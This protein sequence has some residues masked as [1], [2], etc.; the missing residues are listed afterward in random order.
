VYH[1]GDLTNLFWPQRV[2]VARSFA[3]GR[4]P[5]WN[6]YAWGGSPFLAS[7]QPGVFDPTTWLSLWPSADAADLLDGFD[8]QRLIIFLILAINTFA[9]ARAGL[10]LDRG[11][12][13]FGALITACCGFLWW[14]HFDHVNQLSTMAWYPL[15]LLGSLL[16]FRGE[17]RRP[18][19]IISSA[20]GLQVLAGHPQ[21]VAFGCLATAVVVLCLLIF[22]RSPLPAWIRT[23]LV[24]GT[25]Y[26]LGNLIGAVQ[27]LP[28]VELSGLS[29]RI[30]APPD[31]ASTF[32]MQWRH[33]LR[34]IWPH[35]FGVFPNFWPPD[36]AYAEVSL[37]VGRIPLALALL[38]VGA[39]M[40]RTFSGRPDPA[41]REWRFAVW[42]L[43][44]LAAFSI[45]YAAGPNGP[46]FEPLTL[47]APPLDSFRV[48]AR[49]LF[50]LDLSLAL[51]AAAGLQRLLGP[52]K[53]GH[54]GA[55]LTG[56][57]VGLIAL[58]ALADLWAVSRTDYIRSPTP[59][60][61]AEAVSPAVVVMTSQDE[62]P[63]LYR[64]QIDDTDYYVDPRPTALI[65]RRL[66][67][68]P[69]L[70]LLWKIGDVEGYTEGLLPT[71][72]WRDF[73][74]HVHRN[75]H[76]HALDT[77]LLG[78]MGVRWIFTDA[79][80]TPVS[81]DTLRPV[82]QF[83]DDEGERQR[84]YTLLEN[85]HA[86]PRVLPRAVA[87]G[88]APASRLDGLWSRG[89][90]ETPVIHREEVAATLPDVSWPDEGT[91]PRLP[92]R[93]RGPNGFTVV[94]P[95][96]FEGDL[97]LIQ[98]T[99]PGWVALDEVQGR[100]PVAALNAIWSTWSVSSAA[101]RFDLRFEPESYR[102]GLFLSALGLLCLGGLAAWRGAEKRAARGAPEP[103][104]ADRSDRGTR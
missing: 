16:A 71:A 46:L 38:A 17:W 65:R 59:R 56:G 24:C 36:D 53:S 66:R 86:L 70:G 68:Q 3:E 75:L 28:A 80:T 49:M 6:E 30:F 104:R 9:L 81:T 78:V 85:P 48:P 8:R 79:T 2:H 29:H 5:L 23:A 93:R 43:A 20:V 1:S 95:D 67:L 41:T 99:Y 51:L 31:Y 25:G 26:A 91:L 47:L 57:A 21:H 62:M 19:L 42:S 60:R 32:P 92:V 12:A 44:A 77:R 76:Q 97:V 37:F 96:G 101:E 100:R 50:Y 64:L 15:I 83:A 10:R 73:L 103:A 84:L 63:R 33:L 102:V 72:R 87:Q 13:A 82:V 34:L 27:L 40:A 89:E 98:A 18:L 94:N 39:A 69:H 45:L 90:S 22:S 11:P 74:G 55:W 14:G 7:M 4:V 52:L 61:T 58:L 88:I 54:G 35:H